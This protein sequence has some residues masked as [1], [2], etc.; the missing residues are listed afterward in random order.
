MDQLVVLQE[1]FESYMRGGS[2]RSIDPKSISGDCADLVAALLESFEEGQIDENICIRLFNCL[3]D[4]YDIKRL[5]DIC[6]LAGHL[7][8]AARCYNKALSLTSDRHVRSV[9]LNNLGQVHAR[10][11]YLGRALHHYELAAEGFTD[12]GDVG[13]LAHVLGNM[14]SAYRSSQNYDKAME[15]CRKSLEIFESLR[16]DFGVAQM[17]GSLGRIYAETGEFDLALQQYE[18]SLSDFEG[19]GDQRQVAWL[20]NRMGRVNAEMGEEEVAIGYYHKSME[21]FE[22]IGQQQ[23][24]GVVLSNLG[25]L[26]LDRGDYD[27]AADHLETSL[28]LI[29]KSMQPVRANAVSWLSAARS[30]QARELHQQALHAIGGTEEDRSGLDLFV[31]ASMKYAAIGECYSE[32]AATQGVGLP[33]LEVVAGIARFASALMILETETD[34]DRAIKLAEEAVMALNSALSKAEDDQE[35]PSVEGLR[36]SMMGVK[37]AWRIALAKDEPWQLS[38]VVADAT[39]HFTQGVLQLGSA[40]RGCKEACGHLLPAFKNLGRF[41]T[42]MLQGEPP[43]DL[44]DSMTYLKRAESAFELVAPDLGMISS[45]QIRE[46]RLM[47]ERLQDIAKGGTAERG[48]LLE[49]YQRAL[50]LM[51]RVLTRAALKEAAELEVVR[52]WDESMNLSEERPLGKPKPKAATFSEMGA[53]R[54]ASTEAEPMEDREILLEDGGAQ[55]SK[56]PL[57]RPVEEVLILEG[58]PPLGG[59]VRSSESLY[60]PGGGLPLDLP[61]EDPRGGDGGTTST[62]EVPDPLES[63]SSHGILENPACIDSAAIK[64]RRRSPAKYISK[65]ATAL[66][67]DLGEILP[68]RSEFRTPRLQRWSTRAVLEFLVSRG[69]SLSLA[70]VILYLLIDLT[71]Y[72]I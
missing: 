32:L 1:I 40:G 19:L 71:H 17:T 41:M 28:D 53:R 51:G 15:S 5:G 72:F 35:T 29:R 23:N 66:A 57:I 18:K 6:R 30:I 60:R 65:F 3:S 45:F 50:L 20:L 61:L 25:R 44:S 36:R 69:F 54:S 63:P 68:G 12:L 70:L 26:Y 67:A 47:V 55:I 31:E 39:E 8:V 9:L 42:A 24:A 7:G 13:S 38:D 21:I 59:S 16:D 56:P 64:A 11:G 27:L 14:G 62:M 49:T 43:G 48:L 2:S 4:I 52:T 37:E 10:Q 34:A 58:F 33:E 22:G 46:A